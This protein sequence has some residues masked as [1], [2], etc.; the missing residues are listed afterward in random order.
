MQK[1]QKNFTTVM[2]TTEINEWQNVLKWGFVKDSVIRKTAP[3]I[4][5]WQELKMLFKY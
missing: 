2:A 1:K 4:F 5:F 3:P